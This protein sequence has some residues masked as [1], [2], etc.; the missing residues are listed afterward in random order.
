VA[1]ARRASV[2]VSCEDAVPLLDL[3]L[4][5]RTYLTLLEE[6]LPLYADWPAATTINAQPA[7]PDLV[8]TG[9]HAL[10]FYLYHVREDA[11]TKAQ[12]WQTSEVP[13][14]RFKPMGVSLFY[15]LCPKS[16]AAQPRD[17]ALAEQ[18]IMGL[19]L[20]TLHD[21]PSIDDGTAVDTSGGPKLL[22]PPAMR[23][24]NNRL[25]ILL[26]PKPPEDAPDFW[27]GG[28]LPTRLAA[29]Y[30]VNATLL[31]P[32][33]PRR[34]RGRAL[35]VGT[36]LMLRG[37]PFIEGTRNT[38]TFQVPGELAP[39]EVVASPAE[40]PF[41]ADFEIFGADLKGT[42][43]HVQ[44]SHADF[45]EP[46]EV[47]AAWNVRT[48]GDV[49]TV[50][51][52]PTA[53]AQTILPGI[54]GVLVRTVVR[55]KLPDGSARDF[56]AF[57]NQ[58]IV[59]IAPRIVSLVFNA[60]GLGT[61]TVDSFQPH[62][63]AQNDILLFA[64]T[65]KLTRTMTDPPPAGTFFTPAAPPPQTD[66]IRFRLPAGTPTGAV[67]PLRLVVRGAESPPRWEVAP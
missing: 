4:V 19:A 22:M 31:E 53:S 18:L 13:P 37:R 51:A 6:R 35:A 61:I 59:A 26:Q 28:S 27:Q 50:T 66:K 49:V 34:R 36:H 17:R 2:S 47:D 56:D 32:D 65:E 45:P 43:T 24:R 48:T 12:D 11:H 60:A 29:Y 33:E 10:S 16:N 44:L 52:Q 58:V 62:V 9:S 42:R 39:R 5:T 41:G 14:L 40:V 7:P 64:G 21:Y 15:M 67:V 55:S 63:I 8:T 23:G 30:E 57:S 3:G 1:A 38:V 54:Y 46:V 25:R 20:K